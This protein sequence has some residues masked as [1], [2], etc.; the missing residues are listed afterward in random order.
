MTILA[1]KAILSGADNRPP[2]LEKD[3][4]DSWKSRMELTKK[5][6]ELLATEAIQA[7]CDVKATNIILQGL[8]PEVYA[9]VSTHKVAKELWKRIQMLMQGTSLTK[10]ERDCKLYDEFDKFTYRKGESLLDDLD[11]Y[12]SD[13]DELNSAK[14]ALMTNLSHYGSDNLAEDNK[15][16][17]EFLTAELERYI[18]QVRILKE[19]NNVDKVSE[20]CE[21][22]LEIDNLKHILSEHLKE[23]ESLEQKVEELNNIMF[24]RNQ[25]AQ[26]VHMLTKPQFFYDHY[27]RQALGF[28]NPCYL[29]RAQQLEP[30]LY[31]GS[32]IQKT[33]AI[34]ICDSKETLMLEDESRS[35]MLQKQKDPIMSKKKVNTKPVDYAALD[36]LL[37]DFKTRFV[38]QT[39]LSA[40]QAFW[41]QYSVNSK[42]PNLSSSTTI[43]E[44]PKE[45]P[46]VSMVN[47]SLKKL[48]FHLASFDVVVK[49]RTTA[50]TITEGTVTKLVAENEHLKHTYKQLYDSIKSSR[51]RSKEQSLKETLSKLK[52]KAVVNKAVTLHPIDPELLKIDV[53]PLAPKLRNNR[54]AH[55]DYLKHTQEE[56][57]TLKEIVEN[58]RLLNPLNTSLDYTY[59]G[60]GSIPEVPDEPTNEFEEEISWNSTDEEGDDDE[61]KDGDGDDGEEGDGDDDDEDDDSKEGNDD[62][63]DQEVEE[64]DEKDDEEEGGDDEQDSDEKEFFHPSLSTHAEEEPKDEESF[65]P[66]PEEEH[67]EE[68]E[69]DELYRNVNINQ[70]RGIQT[71]QEFKDSHVTLT[72][73]NPDGQQ[74]SLSVSSQ[75]VTSMLNLTPDAG[76]E[77]IFETTSRD[78]NINQGRGIQT[79]Q[80]VEDSHVTITP[81]NPDGMKSIFETTSQMDAQTSTSVAPLPMSAPTLTPSTIA[82]ITITQQAPLP[83]IIALSTL[84]QD[85][86]NF[87]SLFGFDHRLKTLEANFS[88]FSQTNQFTGAEFLKTIDEN[89]QK[90]IKEQ[91]KEQV[92]V[93]VSNILPKIKQTVNEQLEAKVLTRSSNSSKISYVVVA[94][95]S[96]IELKKILIEKMEGNKSIHRSNKQRNLY[97]ALVD[98]Y[99]SDKII[100][101]TYGDTIMLKR[102]RDDDADRDEEPFAGSDWGSKRHREGK[103]PESVSALMETA[104]R[105]AGKSTQGSKSRQMSASE[106]ATAEEPIQT[107]FEMEEPSHPEFE[108]GAD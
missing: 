12:D 10:Q 27:T 105:S 5:Y 58:E 26:T 106:S 37:K 60:T 38:P 53:A 94:D 108:T 14:I 48:K 59:E 40:K 56:T 43:V 87:R 73:V 65:D 84:L 76:M 30:K 8:P 62:N 22:S 2:M 61:G 102:R 103:E 23:K 66:I 31:D 64:D 91:V 71:T 1:D 47:S 98:A 70:G 85:L 55:D 45:L 50:T 89:M 81:V 32:V 75:F 57:A 95:L 79:T 6:S 20:S 69:E 41:S 51:V 28:Q 15:N 54:T 42:E 3:M 92:K 99:E 19:Q 100:L 83:P 18:D 49:E 52:G 78:V 17:N 96:E 86:P 4:Y 67:D 72:L 104:T 34:V 39:E 44:V 82:T 16:V 80:E 9:L 36:Q 29:K 7:D 46:K 97:K 88:E 63:D 21:Q 90:I 25:S 107:T 13:F 33:D 77:S 93:Q 101:D 11:A 24:K 74:Q 68:E 35:K